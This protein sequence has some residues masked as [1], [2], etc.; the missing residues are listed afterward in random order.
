VSVIIRIGTRGSQLALWQARTVA[1]LLEGTSAGGGEAVTCEIV[2]IKTSGD[3]LQEAPLS[4]AGGKRLFVREIED[5]LLDRRVDVAVHSAKDMPVIA[6]DG[7]TIAAVLPREEPWDAIVL[8]AS[9]S[10]G[11]AGPAAGPTTAATVATVATDA[12]TAGATASGAPNEITL[13]TLIARLRSGSGL[14]VGTSS[15]RRVTQLQ[16]VLPGA[17]FAPIRGNLDTRLRKLDEGQYDVLV[18]AAAGLKR[19]GAGERISARVPLEACVPAP[20]QGTIA[21]QVRADDERTYRLA[22]AIGDAGNALALAA[23]Q[24][25]VSALGGGCQTPIGAFAKL[26]A[27]GAGDG[28]GDGG[29]DGDGDGDGDRLDLEAIVISLDGTRALRASASGP[30]RDADAIGRRAAADLLAQGA[31]ELLVGV[32]PSS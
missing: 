5:A 23:E 28:T 1:A 13:D 7:L 22:A 4:E 19:L 21:V 27:A 32:T 30:A 12:T 29:G 2:V 16:R 14:T 17:T 11:G 25:V 8:P 26:T 18:L 3:K 31:A 15:V 20:G 10:A 9:A 24:A 6:V